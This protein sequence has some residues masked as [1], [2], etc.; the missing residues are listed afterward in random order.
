MKNS[1]RF[2]AVAFSLI[3]GFGIVG[4]SPPDTAK[5]SETK[6]ASPNDAASKWEGSLIKRPAGPTAEDAKVYLVRGGKR[7]W[8]LSGDWI[9]SHGYK[10]P[11]DV[12]EI[13]AD[14]L[15]SIPLGEEI[16]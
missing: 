2:S 4:C 1:K 9:R 10:W 14:E 15:A 11:D 6:M 7:C 3:I 12:K 16:H 13:P 8:V 5:K